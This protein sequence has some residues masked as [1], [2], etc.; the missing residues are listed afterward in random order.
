M[1]AYVKL[2][3]KIWQ[4]S[5]TDDP[6]NLLFPAM[7]YT[8][9]LQGNVTR[10]IAEADIIAALQRAKYKVVPSAPNEFT[11]SND[12]VTIH[13]NMLGGASDYA[14]KASSKVVGLRIQKN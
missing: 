3:S 2:E 12:T 6:Q 10:D 9:S 8:Y 5:P 7:S 11:A 14:P 13:V 1:P 4:P